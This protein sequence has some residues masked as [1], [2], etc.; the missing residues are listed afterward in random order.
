[1]KKI[2]IMLVATICFFAHEAKAKTSQLECFREDGQVVW[3][4]TIDDFAQ[5]ITVQNMIV[6]KVDYY[7]GEF[8]PDEI[9]YRDRFQSLG[10]IFDS[11][12]IL[13]RSSL[14]IRTISLRNNLPLADMET[15]CRLAAKNTRPKQI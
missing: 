13:D 2:A 6:G 4:I 8:R 5:N 10:D 1:M 11:T 15:R 14:V 7:R 3:K 9:I 12:Y